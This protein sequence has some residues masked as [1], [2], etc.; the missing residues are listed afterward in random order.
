MYFVCFISKL[1]V[2][3]SILA[4]VCQAHPVLN[5]DGVYSAEITEPALAHQ[6][7]L[8]GDLALHSQADI[9]SDSGLRVFKL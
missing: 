7:E 9:S 3:L 2:Y 4:F 1:F 5:S 8:S 6:S